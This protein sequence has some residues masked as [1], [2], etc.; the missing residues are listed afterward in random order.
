MRDYKG[1][2]MRV[3]VS[4]LVL[5][6]EVVLEDSSKSLRPITAILLVDYFAHAE[7]QALLLALQNTHRLVGAELTYDIYQDGLHSPAQIDLY[8]LKRDEA[9]RAFLKC[10]DALTDV[11]IVRIR[12]EDLPELT[13]SVD[14]SK[15]KSEV[16]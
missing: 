2:L 15:M 7:L 13:V 9:G 11:R 12:Y 6:I 8:D 5:P 4:E 16:K 1:Y 3:S 14:C 10:K